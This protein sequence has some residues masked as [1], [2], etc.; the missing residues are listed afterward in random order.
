MKKIYS[1][2]DLNVELNGEQTLQ[3]VIDLPGFDIFEIENPGQENVDIRILMDRDIDTANLIEICP[4][5]R[6]KVLDV[7]HCFSAH[8]DG[9]CFEMHRLD[10][11]RIVSITYNPHENIVFMSPCDCNMSIKYA[12]WIAYLLAAVNRNVIP[13]HAS[14][15]VKNSQAVLFL[16]ESG[17]GK[18]THTRLWLQYIEDS[19]LL[20][21]DSPLLCIK[22]DKILAYGSPWSGKTD[23]Y[24]Q[25]IF[26]LKAIVRLKQYPENVMTRFGKLKSIGAIQPS[27]PPFLAYDEFYTQ[28]I[29]FLIDRIVSYIPV[30]EFKCLPD[31]QA[32]EMAYAEIH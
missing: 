22:N 4:I 19:H 28:K 30:Y 21:D 31:K 15:I 8:R 1:I 2:A 18:S 7:D 6:F 9:Y 17:T 20:N 12:V 5:H 27:F 16:G 32:A 29:I 25:E 23:C 26:P 14:A 11:S 10:K 24:K 13:I 3:R